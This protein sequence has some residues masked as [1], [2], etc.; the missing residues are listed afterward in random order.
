MEVKHGQDNNPAKSEK[1]E[2]D[3]KPPVTI[4]PAAEPAKGI[5]AE[6]TPISPEAPTGEEV[7]E[8]ELAAIIAASQE[9]FRD[10]GGDNTAFVKHALLP[11]L[12]KA[13]FKITKDK[14]EKKDKD[15]KH[16]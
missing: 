3:I 14:K 7:S 4:P 11:R 12:K 6:D 8:E 1:A 5:I 16:K 13:G 9:D 2:K 15:D 10:I